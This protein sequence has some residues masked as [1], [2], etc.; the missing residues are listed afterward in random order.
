MNNLKSYL[1]E[2]NAVKVCHGDTPFWL[3]SGK[4]SAYF[5]NTHF[6]YGSEE[7]AGSFLSFID[8]NKA[9]ALHLP[10]KLLD[11]VKAQYDNNTIYHTVIDEM[12]SF[13]KNTISID[14]IDYIS[15][16]ER[17]DWF[18]SIILAYL[19]DKPHITIFKNLSTYVSDSKMENTQEI[20]S[21]TGKK[22]LHV[23]DLITVASSFIRAWIPAIQNLGGELIW[24][25]SVVDRMQGG[26]Q[27]L[28]DLGL[29]SYSLV[30]IDESLFQMAF[31]K[32]MI[33]DSQFQLVLDYIK[34]PEGS[35]EKFVKEHPEFI[36]A[37]LD[38]AA[39]KKDG[40]VQLCIN[41]H[42]YGL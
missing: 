17:R 4:L 38:S 2:T 3:T 28:E 18:F 25:L 40:R 11:K 31:E 23:T 22:V 37:S 20:T 42:F 19:L 13:I 6:I 5:I 39:N 8:E 35:M 26:K 7:D 33:D 16:G 34:D 36:E 9:D 27:R 12:L 14:D 30:S 21:I 15:G 24:A 10:K 41:S 32:G 1:F 29:K